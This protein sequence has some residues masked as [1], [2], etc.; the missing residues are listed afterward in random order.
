MVRNS[1]HYHCHQTGSQE[2]ALLRMLYIVTLTYIFK[3]ITFEMIISGKARASKNFSIMTFIDVDVP[4]R[5]GPLRMLYS[6]TLT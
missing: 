4:H 3:V 6:A 2:V 1:K 5:M